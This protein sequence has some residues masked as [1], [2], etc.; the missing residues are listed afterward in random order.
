LDHQVGD[1]KQQ[2]SPKKKQAGPQGNSGESI[3]PIC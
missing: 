2:K 3:Q 1:C